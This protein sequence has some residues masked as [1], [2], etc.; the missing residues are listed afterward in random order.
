MALFEVT[1]N[2]RR[3]WEE[4][5]RDFLPDRIIDVHTHVWLKSLTTPRP[6]GEDSRAVLWPELVAADNSI[7]DLQETY[8]LLFPGKQVSALM[9]TSGVRSIETGRKNNDYV[10]AASKRSGWPALYYSHPTQSADEVEKKIRDGGFL[11][12]KSY[13]SLSPAYIPEAEVRIFDFFPPEQLERMNKMGAIVML[14]VPRGL[15]LRDPVN[16][17]QILEIKERWP[18][19]RLIVAHVGRA[20]TREDVGNAFTDYLNRVPDLMYD[21]CANCCE[22]AITEVIKNAGPKHVM[23]G[24]DMPILRMR[25]HRIEENGTYV[26]LIPP[27]LYG[28]PSQDRHLREVSAKEAE[29]ITFFAYEE[30][31]AFKRACAK[32]GMTPSD[33]N[34]MM[35]ANADGLIKGARRSIYGD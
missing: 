34:D 12:L 22:F 30:L 16:L 4:E 9:F 28:D 8:R 21:F 10:S 33:V 27:G 18:D 14:H 29:K 25:T 3:I 32:L 1:E 35:F 20:Y 11:G 5:L 17:A 19:L 26:N 6:A 2:D 24:T 15:R 7:E 13:L 23:F 31:L